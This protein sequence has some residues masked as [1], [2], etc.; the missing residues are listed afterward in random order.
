[1]N[2]EKVL[3]DEQDAAKVRDL[4]SRTAA[5][6]QA[7]QTFGQ[8]MEYRLAE[9]NEQGRKLF[10]ELGKKHNLDLEHVIYVPTPDGAALVPT[11]VRLNAGK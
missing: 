8:T 3:L 10:S 1:M 6:Q 11:Q 5:C 4:N 9:L 2:Y 7:L